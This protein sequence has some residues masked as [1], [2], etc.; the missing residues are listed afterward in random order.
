[1]RF[2]ERNVRACVGNE[3]S[4]L[5]VGFVPTL[6]SA[7]LLVAQASGIFARHGLQVRLC[8]ELGWAS[9]REKLLHGEMDATLAP[10]SLLLDAYGGLS[11]VRQPCVT[12]LLFGPAKPVLVLAK[13][14]FEPGVSSAG[15]VLEGL[16]SRRGSGPLRLAVAAEHGASTYLLRQWFDSLGWS[17]GLEYRLSVM[18]A[19]LMTRALATG[20]LDGFCADALAAAMAQ[21]AGC[22]QAV[23]EW[24]AASSAGR[25]TRPS[26]APAE[27]ALIVS[28]AFAD[29]CAEVHERL[30][31]A[32]L[33]ASQ[34]G[35][36][37]AYRAE[38]VAGLSRRAAWDLEPA[39]LETL[40]ASRS[41][42]GGSLGMNLLSVGEPTRPRGLAIWN[43]LR[44]L[45]AGGT[46]SLPR[47]VVPRVFR[48]EIFQRA[49]RR[50]TGAVSRPAI[51]SARAEGAEPPG[52]TRLIAWAGGLPMAIPSTP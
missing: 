46:P 15:Q 39:L 42:A 20:Y 10:A 36:D 45:T 43:A 13:A 18:S 17:A 22:G 41:A 26:E 2:T 14:L 49:C 12:G 1:M 6:E 35:D 52:W 51:S 4:L 33:E 34:L 48:P 3:S 16:R 31:A 21:H 11:G 47:E 7:S 9:A 32:L 44:V 38:L 29:R 24:P 8:R 37:P 23:H 5:N 30:I 40:L 28:R 19:A 50:I 25:E 27:C